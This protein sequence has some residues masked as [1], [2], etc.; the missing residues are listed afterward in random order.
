VVKATVF[1]GP[2]AFAKRFFQKTKR[3]PTMTQAAYY[4][5]TL[6]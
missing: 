4:S 2:E 1:K 3:E 5:A 6:A